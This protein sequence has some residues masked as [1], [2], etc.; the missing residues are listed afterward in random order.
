[1]T[2]FNLVHTKRKT[3]KKADYNSKVDCP[4]LV[5]LYATVQRLLRQSGRETAAG[6]EALKLTHPTADHAIF[7]ISNF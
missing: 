2:I 4:L 6:R 3:Y 7:Y 5:P 1:M